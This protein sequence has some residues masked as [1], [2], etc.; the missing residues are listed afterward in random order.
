MPRWFV[1]IY[2]IYDR[3]TRIAPDI[4]KERRLN[5]LKEITQQHFFDSQLVSILIK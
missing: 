5:P 2:N 4:M 1:K 3:C